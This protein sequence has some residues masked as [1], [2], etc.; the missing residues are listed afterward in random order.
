MKFLCR[1][2][3]Q[4]QEIVLGDS[5]ELESDSKTGQC[6]GSL[7]ARWLSDGHWHSPDVRVPAIQLKWQL[8]RLARGYSK[9]V[10]VF[11]VTIPP[12]N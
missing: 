10:N 7:E 12:A 4:C 1:Q 2:T 5:R 11:R 9:W 3:K 6:R 8:S